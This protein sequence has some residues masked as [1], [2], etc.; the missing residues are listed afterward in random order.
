M[1]LLN[2]FKKVDK[3]I[4]TPLCYL[5]GLFVRNKI[6]PSPEKIKK[7]LIIKLIAMGDILVL[8]PTIHAVRQ[9]YPNAKIYFLTTSSMK[10][11]LENSPD[12]DGIITLT[13]PPWN[14]ISFISKLRQYK[15]DIV[16]ELSHYYR[17]VSLITFFAG[18]PHRIGFDISG[19][20]RNTLLTKRVKY[21]D[22]LHE[23]ESFG[24]IAAVIGA[25][26]KEKKLIAPT[27]RTAETDAQYIE[28]F[29]QKN[30]IKKLI[31]IH[32][33][34]SATAKSRRWPTDRFAKLADDLSERGYQIAFTG[35]EEEKPIVEKILS[36]SNKN[37]TNLVGQTTL[38][39]L[40]ELFK[41]AKLVIS[42]DTGP[43]HLAASSGTP[44]LGLYGANTP[45]KWGPYG[46]QHRTIYHGPPTS[47]TQQ[48][49]GRV[50]K[51]PEGY[52]MQD[53]TV[54]EVFNTAL[55][56]LKK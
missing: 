18:I 45:V 5:L 2:L 23:V 27:F 11:L 36:Q 30:N 39:Q 25:P 16:L 31:A 21:P 37:H 3:Y 8:L 54:Q 53:I 17:L 35:A 49:Y 41:R 29:L 26:L 55:S 24:C 52:H 12:L 43:L 20:G 1:S 50:C 4:G 6:P 42:L 13:I 15:F 38:S 56:M 33:G 48:Q 19:Q 34:T 9:N 40:L 14:F 22:N 44:V 28:T 51:H 47:C 32:P 7:I 46:S 10:P